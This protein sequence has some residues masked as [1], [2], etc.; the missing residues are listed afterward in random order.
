MPA[1]FATSFV[2]IRRGDY[3]SPAQQGVANLSAV[4]AKWYSFHLCC[5]YERDTLRLRRRCNC[6]CYDS[7]RGPSRTP[8]PT[9]HYRHGTVGAIINRPCGK[10]SLIRPQFRR[11]STMFVPSV[12]ARPVRR[13]VV[14]IRSFLPEVSANGNVT[15]GARIARR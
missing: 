14:A 12:I 5:H 3:Q 9:P 11:K 8:V 15:A 1:V 4:S 6:C 2:R 7:L 13:L 10:L